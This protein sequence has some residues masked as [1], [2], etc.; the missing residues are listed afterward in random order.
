MVF[1][2]GKMFAPEQNS[3]AMGEGMTFYLFVGKGEGR[4]T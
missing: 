4:V 1:S 2:V 3:G